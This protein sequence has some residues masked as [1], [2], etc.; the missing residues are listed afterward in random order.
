[1]DKTRTGLDHELRQVRHPEMVAA[2][3]S[4]YAYSTYAS[5]ARYGVCDVCGKEVGE[6]WHGVRCYPYDGLSVWG[7]RECVLKK[8]KLGDYMC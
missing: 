7:C 8:M 4:H 3:K 5:S 6:V 2:S 1:M